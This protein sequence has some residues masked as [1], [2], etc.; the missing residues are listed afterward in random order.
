MDD[1]SL[2]PSLIRFGSA[3]STA[4][5]RAVLIPFRPISDCDINR[6]DVHLLCVTLRIRVFI[7][8]LKNIGVDLTPRGVY[9]IL[10]VQVLILTPTYDVDL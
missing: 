5:G 2:F 4:S 9:I 6:K 3:R 1:F 10:I 8:G 7:K